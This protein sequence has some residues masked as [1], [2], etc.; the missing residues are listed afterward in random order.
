[1][2]TK[3]YTAASINILLLFGAWAEPGGCYTLKGQERGISEIIEADMEKYPDLYRG[4]S[5]FDYIR[6]FKASNKI[7]Q[8]TLKQG[9]KLFFP[10]TL[11]SIKARMKPARTKSPETE[12]VE[13]RQ[14]FP[15]K[16]IVYQLWPDGVKISKHPSKDRCISIPKTIEGRPV[17]A[18]DK[19]AF[20]MQSDTLESLFIP[21]TIEHIDTGIFMRCKKLVS[22]Q[23][24]SKNRNFSSEDGVLFNKEKTR[25]ICYPINHRNQA[26]YQIPAEV[27]VI[28]ESAFYGCLNLRGVHLPVN[29]THIGDRGFQHCRSLGE[30]EFP[31]S[32]LSI[33]GVAFHN[34]GYLEKI[35]FHGNAP[36]LGP[37]VFKEI[38]Q[39]GTIYIS[40]TAE[41]FNDRDWQD[42]KIEQL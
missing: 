28:A 40:P 13:N 7:G 41:G 19:D 30:V 14:E 18:L 26:K 34:C 1:M 15:A 42:Y 39:V 9:D 23:V 3:I 27:I 6:K 2:H 11:A 21:S 16:N 22:I 20:D 4:E 37:N 10:D 38:S 35:R 24:D 32:V 17:I 36:K 8:R 31:S 25:L 12:T 5:I 33:G 29:L